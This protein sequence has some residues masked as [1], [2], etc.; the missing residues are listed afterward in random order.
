MAVVVVATAI[1]AMALMLAEGLVAMMPA[2]MDDDDDDDDDHDHDDEKDDTMMLAMIAAVAAAAA[3]ARIPEGLTPK[4]TTC[5]DQSSNRRA[6]PGPG[7]PSIFS[8]LQSS[9]FIF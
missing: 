9:E 1:T 8:G 7:L 5:A 2:L 6:A 4:G 3:A